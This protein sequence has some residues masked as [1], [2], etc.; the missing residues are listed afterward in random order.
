MADNNL[1]NFIAAAKGGIA[2]VNRYTVGFGLPNLLQKDMFDLR[3]IELF[4]ESITMPSINIATV[5]MRTFGEQREM[6]YDRNF[7]NVTAT[8]YVDTN[9]SV[10]SFFDT[11]VNSVINPYSRT[12]SYYEDYTT[13]LLIT[14]LNVQDRKVYQ[15]GLYEVYPKSVGQIQ[16]DN[17]AKDIMKINVN[18]AYKYHISNQLDS[19]TNESS[20]TNSFRSNKLFSELNGEV[21]GDYYDGGNVFATSVPN[22]Y[23]NS[24]TSYQERYVDKTAATNALERLQRQGIQTGVGSLYG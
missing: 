14:V 5:P 24:F 9:M 3:A 21:P 16:L 15:V 8:F 19:G 17:N 1:Q 22:E 12:T 18:F 10:K 4:C 13:D 6:P 11:W 23:T 20:Y 2:R 7:E